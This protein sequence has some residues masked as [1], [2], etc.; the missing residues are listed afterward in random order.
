MAVWSP[1]R[2]HGVLDLAFSAGPTGT[3]LR[4]AEQRP[5]LQVIR[6]FRQADG[7]A[8]VHLH[9]ISGGVLGGDQLALRVSVGPGATAQVTTPGATRLYRSRDAMATAVQE[10]EVVVAE[11]GLLEYVPDPL[12]PYAGARYR[13]ETRIT[14]AAD[15]GLFWWETVAP[16]REAH[17]EVFAYDDLAMTLDLTSGGRLIAAERVRLQPD[18]RPLT[19]SARMGIYRYFSTF[20]ICRAGISGARWLE[21]EEALREIAEARSSHGVALWGVSTLAA[22]GVVVRALSV[23]GAEVTAGLTGFWQAAKVL[24]Y[25]RAAILPRKIY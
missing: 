14:L 19:S 22:D 4:V 8:L 2:V 13:Q 5:P 10:T 21:I 25:G 23:R 18:V 1:R 15:A 24:L 12:I 16:G 20:Y 7:A 17:G 11:G 9:N 6:A 3:S